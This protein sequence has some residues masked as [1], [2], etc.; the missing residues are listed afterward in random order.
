[1]P[2]NDEGEIFSSTEGTQVLSPEQRK[3]R[4][5]TTGT[6]RTSFPEPRRRGNRR[7]PRD[8]PSKAKETF[9]ELLKDHPDIKERTPSHLYCALCDCDIRVRSLNDYLTVSRHIAREK[10]Q[11]NF[12]KRLVSIGKHKGR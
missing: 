4:S 8:A 11:V 7:T 2:V 9:I 10:H 6:T 3:T 12:A 1:M 5:N